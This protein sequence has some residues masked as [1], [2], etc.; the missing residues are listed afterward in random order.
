MLR[1]MAEAADTPQELLPGVPLIEITGMCRVLLENHQGVVQYEPELIQVR[2][3]FGSARI[4]GAGLTITR[5][6][7]RQLIVT[8]AIAAVELER[9][10]KC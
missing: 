2:L 10:S 3:G 6:S 8:G 5:M 4:R 9:G 1:L 7:N